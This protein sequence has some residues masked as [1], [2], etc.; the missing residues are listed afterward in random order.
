[1]F[2]NIPSFFNLPSNVN[3]PTDMSAMFAGVPLQNPL[4][5]DQTK[6][7]EQLDERIKQL[8]SVASWLNLN[9]QMV[10]S[11]VQQLQVQKQTLQA[12]GQWQ[13]MTKTAMAG[14]VKANE[15][16]E[17]S[18]AQEPA[19]AA[20]NNQP[21]KTKAKPSTTKTTAKSNVETEEKI[22]IPI[23]APTDAD[24]MAANLEQ[25]AQ[26]WW[27]GLQNQFAQ[28]VQPVME[29]VTTQVEAAIAEAKPVEK[30]ARVRKPAV[31][32]TDV[33]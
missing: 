33:K 24:D 26:S 30:T 32:K 3:V 11:S 5:S 4:L 21:A 25:I 2:S 10:N 1:M 17:P 9:L 13:E 18:A 31:K 22:D 7:V 15:R 27:A 29:S 19:S 14:F 16:V 20:E 8:E 28:V 6:N 23:A 12:L